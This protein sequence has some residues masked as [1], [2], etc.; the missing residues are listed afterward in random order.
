MRIDELLDRDMFDADEL[1]DAVCADSSQLRPRLYS[2]MIAPNKDLCEWIHKTDCWD[3][4][5][6]MYK[7]AFLYGAVYMFS[8][9][10]R[11]FNIF[12]Q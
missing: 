11:K 8:T 10:Q 6:D 4:V 12:N 7:N 9:L 2:T 1:E 5:D 3:F